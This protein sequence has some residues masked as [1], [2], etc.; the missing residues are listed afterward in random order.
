MNHDEHVLLDSLDFIEQHEARLLTWGLVDGFLTDDLLRDI[1]NPVIDKWSETGNLSLYDADKVVERLLERALLVRFKIDG[2]V[3][4]RSRMAESVRL[5]FRLRQLFPQHAGPVNWQS[6]PT[7]V[8]DFRFIWRRRRY[9]K[10]DISSQKVKACLERATSDVWARE[11]LSVL[12]ENGGAPLDLARF[13]L[14]AAERILTGFSQSRPIGTLV[15]AGT[16]SGKTLAFYLPA[17][18]R[19]VSHIRKDSPRSRWVKALALYPRNELLKDQFSEV[20]GQARK[21]DATLRDSGCRKI[22]IGTLFGPTPY[23][24]DKID[25]R[26]QGDG[27]ACDYL[28]CPTENCLGVMIWKDADRNKRIERLV[29]DQCGTVIESDEVV[30]T[31]ERLERDAPDILFTTTEM[32]NQRLGDHGLRHLFGFGERCTRPVEMMLLDEVHTY[33]G[34]SGAQVA[35]LLRRWRKLLNQPVS[36]V[37][38]SATLADG[39]RFFASLTGLSEQQ[40]REITPR[41]SE[42]TAEGAEYLL[43]LRGDPVSRTALLST[44]IQAGMLMS[45]MLDAPGHKNPK[46]ISEGLWGKR[47]FMFAD[48]LDVINRL[49]F[50]MLDAEGRDS[51]GNVDMRYHPNGGLASIR[52]P[53]PSAQRKLNGQDWEAAVQIG[54]SLQAEDRKMVGRVMSMDPGVDN[55]RDIIVATASLEVGYNDPLVGAVLQ[56]KAPRDVAQFLQRKGRAGRQRRMRPWTVVVLS[57]YGRDR[58]AYQSYDLMFDPQVPA[59]MLPVSNRYVERMQAVY[60]TLDYLSLNMG[61][62]RLGSVWRDVAVPNDKYR[63][64]QKILARLVKAILTDEAELERYSLYLEKALKLGRSEIELLLWDHPR[65]LLTEVLPT[66]L[67]RLESN[68]Q[69]VGPTGYEAFVKNSPLPEFIPPNLFSDLNLPEVEI[70]LPQAVRSNSDP[71][72]MPI[73]Q[74]MRE[75]APGRVSR[76]YGIS[77]ALERHWVCPELDQTDFQQIDLDQLHGPAPFYELDLLGEWHIETD[78]NR[79]SLPVFRP[80]T[81]N[82]VRPNSSVG[83]TSNAWLRWRAQIVVQKT[84]LVLDPPVG[85]A[86]EG[87]VSAVCFYTHQNHSAVQMRRLALGSDADIR[88]ADGSSFKK[89]FQ[90]RFDGKPAAIGFSLNVDAF[91]LR[92][93]FPSDLWLG[94]D[95]KDARYRAVRTAR[96]HDQVV[97]GPLLK[98]LVDNKFAREWLAH[99]MMAAIS[100]EAVANS[101]SLSEAAS[102]L[103]ADEATLGLASTLDVLFRSP[104]VDDPTGKE[105]TQ[106][107]LR[108][109]LI[110]YIAVADV[111]RTLFD[112]AEIL[113]SPIDATWEPWLRER[114]AATTAAAVLHAIGSSCPEIDIDNLHVDLDGGPRD[115]ADVRTEEPGTEIWISEASPG[116]NGQIE[117]VLRQ[118]SEDPRRFFSLMA[119][120]LRDN[121]FALS[122]QQLERFVT[123]VVENDPSGTL[124]Y[125]VEEYRNAGD[126]KNLETAFAGL[127]E[128]LAVAGFVTFHAFIVALANRILRPGSNQESDAFFLQAIRTWNREEER[129]GIELDARVVAYQLSL[130]DELDTA[131]SFAGID[132]PTGDPGKWRFGVIYGLLWPRGAQMRQ[133]GLYLRS[134]FADLPAVEPLLLMRYLEKDTAVIDICTGEWP[135]ACLESLATRGTATLSCPIGRGDLLAAALGFLATNPVQSGYLSVFA[136]IQAIRRSVGCYHLDLDIAEAIQ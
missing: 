84:G 37:G 124:A 81:I 57:D 8:A 10:R 41:S 51:R 86:W 58:L 17:L 107:K 49:Y 56:H 123:E 132:A 14:D 99:L 110:S 1:I 97:N 68:W 74:A 119:A 106:E 39:A 125:A 75:Y 18:S 92:L 121:D 89:Y 80:R 38:L 52:L 93:G 104:V 29:C 128:Q 102:K 136:R 13:Q 87:Y 64:R 20:Y 47:L 131:L 35:Y 3:R 21:L 108:Q 11:A 63:D 117:Q 105:N 112:L 59:R 4:Y 16:G 95:E 120:A 55:G 27:L 7:L 66:A 77:H 127:R 135:V 50:S 72:M 26:P 103:S 82:V 40:T 24:V 115:P 71:V 19:V 111:R 53:D 113:W 90:Y 22:L 33:S 48:N 44:T 6:A 67:R 30:L 116:G 70:R 79:V 118:Y 122:D 62:Q 101:I 25:W 34:T 114:F 130:K 28:R 78:A 61:S 100:N 129:L 85:T 31:R 15:S 42:V 76:R 134:P 73:A 9:P 5:F 98:E 83:D 88:K 2:E 126:S 46:G 43:A 133:A 12:V 36:F 23:S 65:P 94:F 96:Y 109:D 32:L 45:R 60:A 54:H 69:S 91:C